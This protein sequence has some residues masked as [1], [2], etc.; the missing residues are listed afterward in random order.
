MNNKH[1][2]EKKGWCPV[3]DLTCPRGTKAA[4]ACDQRFLGDYTPLTSFRDQD[5]T[6]CAV[7]RT[8][9]GLDKEKETNET[10]IQGIQASFENRN[11]ED[12]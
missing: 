1:K 5:I 8:E 10:A 2:E 4:E 11:N 9:E 6:Y 12:K 7:Y 3:Y